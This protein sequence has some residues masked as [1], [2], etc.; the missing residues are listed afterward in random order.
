MALRRAVIPWALT[1]RCS[2]RALPCTPNVETV[3]S[4]GWEG[5]VNEYRELPGRYLRESC[6]PEPKPGEPQD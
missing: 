2:H 1:E 5:A 4:H 3:M 6:A